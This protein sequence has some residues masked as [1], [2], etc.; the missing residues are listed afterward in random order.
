M[1]RGQGII[2]K[3]PDQ[4]Q[5]IKAEPSIFWPPLV[6]V[7]WIQMYRISSVWKPRLCAKMCSVAPGMAAEDVECL[8]SM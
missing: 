1:R 4:A 5:P 6:S 8:M 3:S 2:M 7:L